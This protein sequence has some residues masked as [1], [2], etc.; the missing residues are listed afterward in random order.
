LL[1]ND[2]IS[3]AHRQAFKE[4]KLLFRDLNENSLMFRRKETIAG[5]TKTVVKG[6]LDDWDMASNFLDE[7]QTFSPHPPAL[8]CASSLPFMALDHLNLTPSA[9]YY[10][11]D[12][13]SFLYILLWTAIRYDLK[14]RSKKQLPA[15]CRAWAGPSVEDALGFKAGLEVSNS[16]RKD[17]L[18]GIPAEWSKVKARWIIPLL[19]LFTKARRSE[20]RIYG[21]I[22]EAACEGSQEDENTASPSPP[23]A[24]GTAQIPE[25]FMWPD[26][27]DSDEFDRVY[28]F[29]DDRIVHA[30]VTH[31]PDYDCS[32]YGGRLTYKTFMEAIGQSGEDPTK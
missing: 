1:I 5:A 14:G 11:H 4:G 20:P 15:V 9:H 3:L 6:V 10:R 26:S 2:T 32:T 29:N 17:V 18:S 31:N 28:E 21:P 25:S 22:S 16:M 27:S 13:E 8:Q 19:N 30:S 12:L 24:A 7:S 23:P